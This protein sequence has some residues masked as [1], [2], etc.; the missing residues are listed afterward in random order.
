MVGVSHI[1]V[2]LFTLELDGQGLRTTALS[3][4]DLPFNPRYI[5]SDFQL[6]HWPLELVS[7]NLARQ[8][9]RLVGGIEDSARYV[10]NA[11]RKNV[12][13]V[14]D[15]RDGEDDGYMQI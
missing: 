9:Y 6:A 4:E 13:S 14:E 10:Y 15:L 8:G 12:A 11:D 5:L 3:A 2:P 1:G 7:K